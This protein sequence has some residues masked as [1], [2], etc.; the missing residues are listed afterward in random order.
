MRS[1]SGIVVVTVEM[2]QGFLATI[3]IFKLLFHLTFITDG[4]EYM[5][6]V[7]PFTKSLCH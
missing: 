7:G 2:T 3:T 5:E 6:F 4:H 1:V